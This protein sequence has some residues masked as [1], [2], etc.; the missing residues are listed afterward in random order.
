MIDIKDELGVPHFTKPP[1]RYTV[2]RCTDQDL[3]TSYSHIPKF[4]S[5]HLKM[6]VTEA[7]RRLGLTKS[8]APFQ[9]RS[10]AGWTRSSR[11]IL[12]LVC[13]SFLL[14]EM[15]T[16]GYTVLHLS[17]DTP[18]S[19]L[20]D[21]NKKLCSSGGIFANRSRVAVH[22]FVQA[23]GLA[24][25]A[26]G[27]KCGWLRGVPSIIDHEIDE[28]ASSILKC[29]IHNIIKHQFKHQFKH[30]AVPSSTTVHTEFPF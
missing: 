24:M 18:S 4:P 7:P 3:V 19:D 11:D 30:P 25:A 13:R 28:P 15:A 29:I 14:H 6:I 16:H 9:G 21:T 17:K 1:N 23:S 12:L 22:G 26:S 2:Y 10:S 27:A 20:R 5:R 8:P